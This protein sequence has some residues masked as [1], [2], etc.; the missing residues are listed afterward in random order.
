MSWYPI[1][2]QFV[3]YRKLQEIV[4]GQD[5]CS[6]LGLKGA[7]MKP[8]FPILAAILSHN[9]VPDNNLHVP[10]MD[11]IIRTVDDIAEGGGELAALATLIAHWKISGPR[12]SVFPTLRHT[13]VSA[14]FGQDTTSNFM[15]SK[16]KNALSDYLT[17]RDDIFFSSGRDTSLLQML[18]CWFPKAVRRLI[19][20][21]A[22]GPLAWQSISGLPVG[23]GLLHRDID[24]ALNTDE[25]EEISALSW[26]AT[27]QKHIEEEL[28]NSALEENALGLEHHLHRGRAL[29]AFN[30]FLGLRVQKLKSEGQA[31]VQKNVQVDVQTLLGPITE[32][33]ESLL[34][35]VMPLAI[36]HLRILCCENIDNLRKLSTKGSAFHAVGH[37]NDIMESLARALADEY[38]QQDSASMAKKKG[39][40]SLAARKQ[41][42]RALML[43]LE[44]LEKASLPPMVD[45]RTCGSWLLSGDGDGIELRSQQKAASHH[46][47]LVTIFCQMHHLPLSTRYLSVLARDN[48]WVGFC[49]KLRS[50]D[51][52]LTQWSMWRQRT[53]AIHVS[54]FIFQQFERHAVKKKS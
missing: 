39:T 41:P 21:Y 9:L 10:V 15:G 43:F 23:E 54:K 26:E 2:I 19:Q 33:E 30:H 22:Q 51:I 18:P 34:S 24:F 17:W 36:M 47:N 3:H 48:D 7:S 35:S 20:L 12:F 5:G 52:L 49:Q 14:C 40:P 4:N 11:E 38:L 8:H 6:S 28:Y 16:A 53:L 32:S 45:G 42:S 25:D 37:E 27:I 50:E 29:A 1:V 31:H 13:F 44:H 46:W